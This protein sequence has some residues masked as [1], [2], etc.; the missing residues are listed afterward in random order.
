MKGEYR[1]NGEKKATKKQGKGAEN[2]KGG[3]IERK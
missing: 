2:I 1:K 3:N